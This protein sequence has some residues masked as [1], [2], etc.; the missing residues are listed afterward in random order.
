MTHLVQ[1]LVDLNIVVFVVLTELS[2]D[3]AVGQR[4]KLCVDFVNSGPL[5]LSDV[6]CVSVRLYSLPDP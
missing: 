4:D 5:P 6:L 3:S 1:L 2:H